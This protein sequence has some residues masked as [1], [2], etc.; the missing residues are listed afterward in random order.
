MRLINC[1]FG[2]LVGLILYVPFNSYGHV[3]MVHEVKNHIKTLVLAHSCLGTPFFMGFITS[4]NP[5]A[6]DFFHDWWAKVTRGEK[7]SGSFSEMMGPS[8][9]N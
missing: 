7:N 3:G 5:R 8:I 6:S 4:L 9:S 2:W 1:R